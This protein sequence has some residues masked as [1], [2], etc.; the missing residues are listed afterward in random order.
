[1]P[2]PRTGVRNKPGNV[3]NHDRTSPVWTAQGPVGSGGTGRGE[4][5]DLDVRPLL[6]EVRESGVRQEERL[7]QEEVASGGVCLRRR[8]RQ[9]ESASGGGAV[10]AGAEDLQGV[11]DVLEPVLG[12]DP[13]GPPLDGGPLD[14]DGTTAV[15]ADQVVVVPGAA[16]PVDG[17]TLVGAQDVDL[18]GLGE[19]LEG[20]VDG[21]EPD[22]LTGL[23][24]PG[25]EILG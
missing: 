17:L 20:P 5:R 22:V 10:R 11:R 9:V 15:A 6:L 7:P 1:L 2:T 8:L 14:L 18:A 19:R 4:R 13:L 23:P 16:H 12:G 24:Q 25:V 21:G 3:A